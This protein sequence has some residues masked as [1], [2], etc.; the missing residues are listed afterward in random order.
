MS[1]TPLRQIE[2]AKSGR[3]GTIKF[4]DRYLPDFHPIQLNQL[5]SMAH[6][7]DRW[8]HYFAILYFIYLM[9]KFQHMKYWKIWQIDHRIKQPSPLHG[10]KQTLY[11]SWTLAKRIVAW[12]SKHQSV[13]VSRSSCQG[14]KVLR[15]QGVKAS[16]LQGIKESRHQGIKV[17]RPHGIKVSTSRCQSIK[18]SRH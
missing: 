6:I 13:K 14:V 18:A 4:P 15:H 1:E 12:D 8:G 17:S 16:R 10:H 7:F 11:T 2:G 5:T 3:A 9:G